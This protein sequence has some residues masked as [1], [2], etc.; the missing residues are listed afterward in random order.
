M[1]E[2]WQG[3]WEER[4]A[5]WAE[6]DSRPK[7][8]ATF[9]FPYVN[10]PPH[11]GS[12]FTLLRVEF[13]SRYMRMKGYNVLF[14]QGWHATGGPIVSAA[15]RVREGDPKQI[16]N[17]LSMGVPKDEIPMFGDP[18]HWVRY[19]S[20][21]WRE[22]LRRLGI[23][24]DWRREFY[25]TRLNPSYSAFVRWQYI[26]LRERGLV[27]KGAHPVVWCPKEQKVVGDH[28][29]PDEYVGIG[30]EE[31][32]VIKFRGD[33]GFIYPCLTYRPETLLGV[34]NIWVRM[35]AEYAVANVDGETWVASRYSLDELRDQGHAVEVLGH[36]RGS[37]LVNRIVVNPANG[38]R[39]PVLPAGFV[40]PDLGTG[41][42]MSV[43]AH[44]PYDY[45][46]LRDVKSDPG[47]HGVNP[48]LVE[49]L[50]P[51]GIIRVEGHGAAPAV[52][53]VEGAGISSQDDPRLEHLTKEIYSLEYY[54]GRLGDAFGDLSGVSVR[55]GKAKFADRLVKS[56]VALRLHTLPQ[57]V[58]CR[59]GAR[60]HVKIV[61][62]QWFLRY[63]DPGWKSL[64]H[65][66]VDSMKFY[67]E[68]V[69]RIFHGQI[70]WLQDWAC[71]H[72][73][74]LGTP[75]PWDED[76]MV[77]SLSD[78]TVYMAYY[79]IAKYLQHT[80]SYGIDPSRLTPEFFDYVLLGKGD[81]SSVAGSTGIREELIRSMRSE[82]LYWYPVD[83]RNSGKDLMYNHL[84]FFI[85]HHA[86]IFPREHWPRGIGI[87]GWVL[88]EGRKMSK[89]AGNFIL[90]RDAVARWG[91]D[92]TRV[93]EALAGDPGLEDPSF[94][95]KVAANAVDELY[96]WYEFAVN[97]YG[98]GRDSR[99]KVDDWFE[100]VLNRTLAEVDSLMSGTKFRSALVL[101][102]YELQN[103]FRWYMRRSGTPNRDLM[104][105]FIEVQTLL[106]APF[107]PHVAEEI[108]SAIGK[109]GLVS[110]SRWPEP[111]PSRVRPELEAAEELVMRTLDDVRHVLSLVK[112]KPVR[113]RI[114]VADPWKYSFMDSV[115]SA[116]SSG[117]RLGD[118]INSAA[119]SLEPGIRGRAAPIAAAISRD[120][121]LL[122]ISVGRDL[123]RR[124][125]EE[126]LE[127]MSSEL[128]L[129]VVLEDE[130]SSGHGKASQAVPA[131][132]AI[133]VD[134]E[135]V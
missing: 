84:V 74:E 65:E 110:L 36:V 27:A 119:R 18:E 128:K 97:N 71:A 104:A 88:V 14:A 85:Y 32:F 122:A 75:L 49:G 72:K 83:F 29:R 68:D 107:A 58:Y 8:M 99:L 105:R 79:T 6:P 131:R 12:I 44:A 78:S 19:F 114:V 26:K 52:E 61:D 120:P 57:R 55:E 43:P 48:S 117:G 67:P 109:E 111:D 41:I 127:F 62:D 39:V 106:L 46:A 42:V 24:V 34:T 16:S 4:R 21:K 102:F 9:P 82:F 115:R 73:G 7:F 66:C 47:R 95:A 118:A 113:V 101:G 64:A 35:D 98:R 87:N 94:D 37:D 3:I 51:R 56:G 13:M 124:A 86:A 15:L 132:P 135:R 20:A 108:W 23:S 2:K 93:A 100:S 112:G 80:D 5:F 77:E 33:D 60:T 69:R 89:T 31:A 1:E 22:D 28:D 90:A 121:G 129:P 123:E 133:I 45:A 40:D 25:T 30:P 81:P 92:A 126:A 130:Q 11:I 38:D 54:E 59:C 134:V 76:W 125:L 10:A 17:L 63:S 91:A 96:A 103:R 116:L 70:D 53:A 50:V